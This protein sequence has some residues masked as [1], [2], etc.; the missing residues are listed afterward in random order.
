MST[1]LTYPDLPE[2]VYSAVTVDLSI[3]SL[4]HLFV[5]TTSF[6]N[7]VFRPF[8][9]IEEFIYS[10]ATS[11]T[12]NFLGDLL[13]NW[14]TSL[15]GR[16]FVT[17]KLASFEAGFMACFVAGCLF[18]IL[19]PLVGAIM[20]CCRTCCDNCGGEMIQSKSRVQSKWR[21]CF[22]ASLLIITVFIMIPCVFVFLTNE[23][24]TQVVK[25]IP[26][27]TVKVFNDFSS[28]LE[29]IPTQ[30]NFIV[31]Q[32][33]TLDQGLSTDIQNLGTSVGVPIRD[34]FIALATPALTLL[35]GIS[36]DADKSLTELVSI[37]QSTDVLIN[38]SN[39]LDSQLSSLR[40]RMA[41]SLNT[42]ECRGDMY[43]RGV[44]ISID[45]LTTGGDFSAL[46][47]VQAQITE[48]NDTLTQYDINAEI[49]KVMKQLNDIP[50]L[51][52]NGSANVTKN[53]LSTLATINETM[54]K[55]I[56]QLPLSSLDP[57][58]QEMENINS[59]IYSIAYDYSTKYDIYRYAAG[60]VLGSI[61][62]LICA[63]YLL[64]MLCGGCG[65]KSDRN[66]ADR[67]TL[68]NCG[69]IS[70]M[71]G[72][73]VSFIFGW[74]LMLLVTLTFT[75][76]GHGERYVCQ[77]L[78]YPY[79]GIKFL[80]DVL[81]KTYGSLLGIK[82]YTDSYVP[83]DFSGVLTACE[84]NS[85]IYTALQLE[86]LF[87]VT[88]FIQSAT[89]NLNSFKT[90]LS[91]LTVDLSSLKAY[92]PEIAN[93]LNALKQTGLDGIN[94]DSYLNATA[95]GITTVN[96]TFYA[97]FLN[98]S[99]DNM[100]V[101]GATAP[102]LNL[103]TEI[104]KFSY[105]VTLIQ[106][107]YVDPLTPALNTLTT[108]INSLQKTAT[109]LNASIDETAAALQTLDSVIQTNG[110]ALVSVEINKYADT[111]ILSVNQYAAWFLDQVTNHFGQCYPVVLVY[112]Q[113]VSILCSYFMDILN[114]LWFCLGW[115][116]FFLIPGA[117]FGMKLAKYYR[118]LQ[119]MES[120]ND[121]HWNDMEMDAFNRSNNNGQ[122][123]QKS[124]GKFRSAKIHP[125]EY[126]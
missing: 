47:S 111:L 71:A 76:G 40:S 90:Q 68:S 28:Y 38:G 61:V 46:Q 22:F 122:Q 60:I 8:S 79:E 52:T 97:Q 119:D 42:T 117:I 112:N 19:V 44:L 1:N 116:T 43:C 34:T 110:S 74:I 58:K 88:E 27:K 7:L 94:F 101:P 32:Y 3:V 51:V 30:F 49:N 84:G 37:Q 18:I 25:V 20:C 59:T 120:Y 96:F 11:G 75:V 98:N 65:F 2:N 95:Q 45:S 24:V 13:K 14:Q 41:S 39:N 118:R 10:I 99:A 114:G 56:S 70:I 125:G 104:R 16:L 64:G 80:D 87:N 85:S 26:D 105:E 124:S 126:Y 21:Y 123:Q 102:I 81:W 66:P 93:A 35:T 67:S 82:L 31:N 83:L 77:N 15:P 91:D 12:T 23:W 89:E 63:L 48:I 55:A 4:Q 62:A 113:F 100:T 17:Y 57:L 108:D 33:Y 36:N 78:E 53:M 54:S 121:N 69:G 106:T 50:E 6:I 109:G 86:E 92:T 73:G 115:I 103:A 107:M 72:V 9:A 5:M 29:L